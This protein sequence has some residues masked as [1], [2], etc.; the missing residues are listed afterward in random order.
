MCT[1]DN[2]SWYNGLGVRPTSNRWDW[3]QVY[4]ITSSKDHDWSNS[5]KNKHIISSLKIKIYIKYN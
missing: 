2:V 1:M 4:Q 5:K 3:H